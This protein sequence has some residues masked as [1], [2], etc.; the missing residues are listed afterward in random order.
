MIGFEYLNNIQL[1][2]LKEV[3]NIGAGHAATALSQ[4]LSEKIEM[5]VPNVSIMH[6]NQVCEVMGGPEQVATGIYMRVF[7]DAPGKLFSY[8]Q[9]LRLWH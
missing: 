3:G 7:G 8:S 4:I 6:L 1:D 5:T 2:A 9:N